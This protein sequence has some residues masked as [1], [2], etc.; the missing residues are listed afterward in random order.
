MRRDPIFYRIFKRFPGLFFEL[1]GRSPTE[2]QGYR[3]EAVEVKE[4]SFRI[5]GVFLPPEDAASKLEMVPV[6]LELGM[7]VE[8]ISERI[9]I[10]LETVR[11]VAIQESQ[12]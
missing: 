3:F 2:F 7:T 12:K 6:L 4:P 10:N 5:D 11:Q 9:G 1:I 8:Q